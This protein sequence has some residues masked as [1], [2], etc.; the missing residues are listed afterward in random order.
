MISFSEIFLRVV[1]SVSVVLISRF[2]VTFA[3]SSLKPVDYT[4]DTFSDVQKTNHFVM[5]YAPWCGHCKNLAPTWDQ[6]AEK[7]HKD[8]NSGLTIGKV[9]CVKET[10]LCSEQDVTGYPTLK[11]FKAGENEGV[12]YRGT[13][14]LK[15]FSTFI[16]EQL[17]ITVQDSETQ[18]KVPEP[19]S[20]LVELT[21]D[22]F[23]DHVAKGRHFVKFY[24][25]W[26]GHCQKL[27]PTWEEL[28]KSLEHDTSVVISKID[29]TAHR[30]VCNDFEIKG[31]PTLLWIEDGKKVDK[32]QG[33]RTI[34][35]LKAFVSKMVGSDASQATR[36][37][38]VQDSSPVVSFSG[39]NFEHGI[40]RGLT[41]VKF[42]APWCG[43]CKR[44]A[45]TWEELGKKFASNSLVKIVK[46]DC[47]SNSNKDLCNDEEVDGFPSLFLYKDGKRIAEYNGSRT[48]D[49]LYEFVSKHMPHDEL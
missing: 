39:E 35:E 1:V 44:L 4:G 21:E 45:P 27:A 40:A 25:P 33:P 13:R 19:V 10:A 7:Y 22:T 3:S 17:G 26:C 15:A 38:D 36:S 2:T 48:L 34:E 37:S 11:F 6:L 41:F 46:V 8:D 12:K 47:T 18:P 30:S 42:F 29:C 24:A 23:E 49:D 31:Y 32:Y 28:A 20:G 16:E 14:S 9:D 43:H 5:F